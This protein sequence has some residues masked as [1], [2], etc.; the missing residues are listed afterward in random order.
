MVGVGGPARAMWRWAVGPVSFCVCP[1][2]RPRFKPPRA[3]PWGRVS[4]AR[5]RPNERLSLLLIADCVRVSRRRTVRRGMCC[6]IWPFSP[7]SRIGAV[8]R[9][10]LATEAEG[11]GRRGALRSAS[12]DVPLLG[13]F[14]A[15]ARPARRLRRAANAIAVGGPPRWFLAWCINRGGPP[16]GTVDSALSWGRALRAAPVSWAYW[17]YCPCMRQ[18]RLGKRLGVPSR[19]AEPGLA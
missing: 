10:V 13:P 3:P 2:S 9:P 11:E 7:S 19:R 4:W 16:G 14:R 18:S 12:H 6:W 17:T 1:S 15:A 5:L 8:H